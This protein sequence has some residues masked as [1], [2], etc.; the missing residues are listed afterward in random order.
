MTTGVLLG[1]SIHTPSITRFRYERESAEAPEHPSSLKLFEHWQACEQQGGMRMGRDVPTRDLANMLSGIAITEPIDQWN[2][3]RIRLAGMVYTTR[4]GRDITGMT[5]REIY[6]R[7]PDGGDALLKGAKYCTT[8]QRV[9][10]LRTRVLDGSAELMRFEVITLPI[11][12]PDCE[13]MWVMA[14][15]YRI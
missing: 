2:D 4:F 5:I 8:H 13:T 12:A 7:D 3:G 15:T 10:T 14:G 9:T 6:D 11:W 1:Q